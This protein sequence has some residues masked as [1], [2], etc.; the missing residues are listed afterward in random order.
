VLCGW[1][2]ELGNSEEGSGKTA[3]VGFTDSDFARDVDSRKNTSSVFF[4]LNESPVTWQST[5]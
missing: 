3:L 2:C 1:Y 5:K 4:F